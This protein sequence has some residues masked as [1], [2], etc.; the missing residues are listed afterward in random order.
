MTIEKLIAQCETRLNYLKNYRKTNIE[1]GNTELAN[2][3]DIE[4]LQTQETLETL[5]TI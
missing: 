3:L 2:S 4:I 5:K 1:L